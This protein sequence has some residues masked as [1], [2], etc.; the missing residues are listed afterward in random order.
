MYFPALFPLQYDEP[1]SVCQAHNL[2][3]PNQPCRIV[4]KKI[5]LE[6]EEVLVIIFTGQ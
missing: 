5:Y 3:S 1:S 2:L 6:Q 4:Y